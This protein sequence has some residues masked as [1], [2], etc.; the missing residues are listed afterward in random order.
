MR[1]IGNFIWFFIY[2]L[3]MAVV[4]FAIGVALCVTLIGIPAGL[5]FIKVARY[6]ICPFGH[7]AVT[8]FD[9]HPIANLLWAI[10]IGWELALV[11]MIVGIALCITL[12]G[13][14]FGK[15]CFRLCALSFLPFGATV[16]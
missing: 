9:R 4:H 5:Q 11:H 15:K 3:W 1:F 2:G 6:A 14:P 13:I 16:A 12:I 10:F 7:N 8:D